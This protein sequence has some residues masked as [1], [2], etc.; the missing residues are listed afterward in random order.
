MAASLFTVISNWLPV[1]QSYAQH[2]EEFEQ[3]SSLKHAEWTHAAKLHEEE[4]RHSAECFVAERENTVRLHNV[5]MRMSQKLAEREATRDARAQQQFLNQSVIVVDVLM[6]S[7]AFNAVSQWAPP[8][9]DG[10]ASWLLVT[11]STALGV[12]ILALMLS[13]WLSFKVQSRMG[14]FASEG[15]GQEIYS[16]G[17][18]HVSFPSYFACHC[19]ALRVPAVAMFLLGTTSL[20]VAACSLK[21][22]TVASL[23]P[24]SY[25]GV[26][27]A[28]V[29]GVLV[30]TVLFIEV[31]FSDRTL[32]IAAA[33]I[34]SE[35]VEIDGDSGDVEED[36]VTASVDGTLHR[37]PSF[38]LAGD[39]T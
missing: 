9:T 3:E 4:L 24:N 17:T 20:L 33:A 21:A 2:R 11:Y 34:D 28:V 5:G 14:E 8:P 32:D 37:T 36:A 10:G 27:F 19:E 25:A 26:V 29:T 30:S 38:A 12:A 15:G 18:A 39:D 6:L 1:L 23:H 35:L 31:L 7:C 13:V 22:V 16:C